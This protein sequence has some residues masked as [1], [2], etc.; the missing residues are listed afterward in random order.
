MLKIKKKKILINKRK[1]ILNLKKF[2][3]KSFFDN[4]ILWSFEEFVIFL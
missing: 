1:I 3:I 4:N 2:V